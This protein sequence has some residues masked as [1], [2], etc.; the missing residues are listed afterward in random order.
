MVRCGGRI[1]IFLGNTMQRAALDAVLKE[2]LPEDR[3]TT[4]ARSR[5]KMA[6]FFLRS[7][8]T[9]TCDARNIPS[10]RWALRAKTNRKQM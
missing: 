10:K 5:G 6:T 4:L 9:L 1:I 2:R 3:L 8:Q 7:H